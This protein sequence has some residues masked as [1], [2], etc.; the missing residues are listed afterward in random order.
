MC[1]ST[2]K[3]IVNDEHVPIHDFLANKLAPLVTR[4]DFDLKPK[5]IEIGVATDN[6]L[7]YGKEA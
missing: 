1:P 3:P 2:L 4:D 7:P 5:T 6:D